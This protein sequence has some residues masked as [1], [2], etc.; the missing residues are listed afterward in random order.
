[1]DIAV[2]NVFCKTYVAGAAKEIFHVAKIKEQAEILQN[3]HLQLIDAMGGFG[4]VFKH[5]LQ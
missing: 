2:G 1:M 5:N 3:I 4:N